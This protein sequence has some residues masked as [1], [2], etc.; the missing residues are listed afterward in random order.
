MRILLLG[1]YSNVHRTLRDA[2]RRQGHDVLLISDGD[3]WKDYPRDI[4]LSRHREGPLGS[5]GYV[6]RLLRLLPRMRGFDVV[7]LINP[8]LLHL[9]PRWNRW[10]FDYL[11][12]HN[13][14]VSV[15]CFGDDYY[16]IRRSQKDYVEQRSTACQ[17][18]EYSDFYAQ[19]RV[20]N[21]PLN[22]QRIAQW[23]HGPKAALTQ[24]VMRQA[25]CLVAC[26]YEYYKVYDT[27]EFSSRLYYIP[28]PVEVSA[29]DVPSQEASAVNAPV[30]VLLAVQ[31]RRASMKGTDQMEPLLQRLAA[32]YPDRIQLQ[33]IESVPF[34][35]YCR[36]LDEADVVV[37][38]L[39][40]YTPAMNALEAMSRGKVVVSGGEEAYYVFQEQADPAM[41]HLRPIVNLRPFEHEQNYQRLCEALLA[42]D[43]VQVLQRQS[44]QFVRQW[45]D[46]DRVAADYVRM[47]Q[48]KLRKCNMCLA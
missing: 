20:I 36:L 30:K 27:P 13:H 5:V 21:H 38:Q 47:W 29:S 10:L 32:E 24:Y 37:D 33:R 23:I 43:H 16:V 28:L 6:Y 42:P 31:K 45:H 4:D 46:A 17:Y 3:G 48:E 8:D 19:G 9:K 39:Y 44:R 1:E 40:S 12:R 11:R 26:L 7:Q 25:D 34:A 14:I 2:L 41:P 18:L 35:E 22:E 15:G